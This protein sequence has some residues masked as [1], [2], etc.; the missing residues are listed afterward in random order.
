M[1]TTSACNRGK[2]KTAVARV[3]IDNN[4]ASNG[5]EIKLPH[6]TLLLR[7]T[8]RSVTAFDGTGTVTITSTDGTTAFFSGVNVK[9]AV[10]FETASSA[11]PKHYPTGGTITTYITDQNSNSAAGDAFVVYEYVE[12][13]E[14]AEVY[15]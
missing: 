5:I 13:S 11:P 12:L 3:G 7:T 10:G 4:G 9:D 2:V 6:N 14:G 15:G 1:S 8:G